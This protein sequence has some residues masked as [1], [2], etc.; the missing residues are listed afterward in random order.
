MNEIRYSRLQKYW[1][2]RG[3]GNQHKK[4]VDT[5]AEHHQSSLA[6]ILP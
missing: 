3:F 2:W 5:V 4:I 1:Q 6:H